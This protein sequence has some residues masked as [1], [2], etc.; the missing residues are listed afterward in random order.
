M[1]LVALTSPPGMWRDEF[2]ATLAS[3]GQHQSTGE[4]P[5]NTFKDWIPGLKITHHLH[6]VWLPHGG[7]NQQATI[8][9]QLQDSQEQLI[10][11]LHIMGKDEAAPNIVGMLFGIIIAEL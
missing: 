8:V 6:Q 3:T 5:H 9:L 1:G 4:N 2:S 7:F 11:V 10:V